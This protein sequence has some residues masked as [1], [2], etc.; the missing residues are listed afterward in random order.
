MRLLQ[1]INRQYFIYSSVILMILG[2]SLYIGLKLIIYEETDEKLENTYKQVERNIKQKQELIKLEPFISVELT[3]SAEERQFFSDTIFYPEANELETYRQLTV[4]KSIGE[5]TYRI[6][7][8]ESA[9]ESEDLLETLIVVILASLALLL[10]LLFYLNSRISRSVWIPFNKNIEEL[11]KFSL[12]SKEAFRPEESN[13]LEFQELNKTLKVLTDKVMSDYQT[14]KKFAEDASHEIQTPLAVIR[15]K[16]EALLDEGNLS[17]QQTD[18]IQAIYQS[19]NRLTRMNKELLLLTK[20]ENR[21]FAEP[22]DISLKTCI[23]QQIE[24]FSEL[25]TMKAIKLNFRDHDEWNLHCD[26]SLIEILLGNLFS[27]AIN[28]NQQGGEIEI[29]L[30]NEQLEISNT[31]TKSIENA[32]RIFDRFYKETDTGSTGLGLSIVRQICIVL[33]LQIDY[34]F[35]GNRHHF[36]VHI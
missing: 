29:T 26:R 28:H 16:V 8:R 6:T 25:I 20:I 31:G 36:I 9:L 32:H 21:Q 14:L 34:N 5:H 1:H 35:S 3:E 19:V 23:R 30:E 10:V 18:K 33:N 17:P 15:S 4:I 22:E 12:Q 27:N 13:I 11:K 24:H 7:L 2:I